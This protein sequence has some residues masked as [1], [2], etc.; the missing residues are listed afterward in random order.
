MAVMLAEIYNDSLRRYCCRFNAFRTSAAFV[1]YMWHA[2]HV[3]DERQWSWIRPLLRWYSRRCMDLPGSAED[4][5][6]D[7]YV[8]DIAFFVVA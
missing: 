1:S 3:R 5:L 6:R 4:R 8:G 7:D 2:L